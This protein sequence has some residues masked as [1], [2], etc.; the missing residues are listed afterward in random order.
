[1]AVAKQDSPWLLLVFQM[2]ARRASQRVQVWRQL[3]RCGAL[4]VPG[5]GYLLPNTPAH[6]ERFE[7]L[8]GLIRSVQGE[9][10]VLH[11]RS[12]DQFTPS[13]IRQRFT[14]ARSRDYE[15]VLRD[16]KKLLA[17]PK[18]T[19]GALPR[20]RRRFQE[21]SAIDFFGSPL[22]RRAEE[23]LAR[24]EG[25]PASA[26]EGGLSREARRR[27]RN[28]TWVTRPRPG[29][30][31]C[32]SAWLIRRF[33]DPRAKFAFATSPR[34]HPDGV[35]FDMFQPGGFGHR[36]EDCTFETLCK[37]FAIRDA[38]VRAL[39]EIVHDA[40]LG[41]GKFCRP[42][43]FGLDLTLAG[44]ARQGLP[45]EEILRWGMKMVDG[46]YRALP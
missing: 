31:R 16:L 9:A 44:W 34:Q 36:G 32:A 18:R 24:A 7:W 30:D 33:I 25:R 12:F 1:M 37:E 20:L 46:L 3:R 41:D 11:V 13:Q 27:F 26:P 14:E 2:P 19:T 4:S 8:A 22:R 15:S 42:E 38:R 21:I 29:I 43:G 5:S 40:D 28:R 10:S 39:A 23:L 35:A 6:R 17:T 45:D